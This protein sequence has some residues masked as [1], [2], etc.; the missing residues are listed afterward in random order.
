MVISLIH[1]SSGEILIETLLVKSTFWGRFRGLL[2]YRDLHEDSAVLLITTKRV[3]TFGMLFPL[4]MYFFDSSLVLIDFCRGIKQCKFPPS[5]K[6]TKHILE[7]QH[8]EGVE[9]LRLTKGDKV[10]ILWKISE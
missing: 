4:D 10:S 3:H 8:R 9:P 5:P 2:F 1:C 7:V 6:G